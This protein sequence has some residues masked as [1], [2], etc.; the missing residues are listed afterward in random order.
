MKTLITF[1]FIVLLGI[2]SNAHNHKKSNLVINSADNTFIS[3]AINNSA[4]VAPSGQINFANMK[5]GKH[6]VKIFKNYMNP[7]G[8]WKSQLVYNGLISVPPASE[9]I[10]SLNFYNQLILVA[11]NPLWGYGHNFNPPPP[12]PPPVFGMAP[13]AFQQLVMT[14]GNTPF[15]NTRLTIA[16]QAIAANGITSEQV[17]GLMNM[18]TFESHKLDLA[19]YAYAFTADPNNYYI[20]NNGFTFTSSIHELNRFIGI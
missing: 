12:P 4:P 7:G 18:L 8:H 15:D 9:V 19:K 16:K 2:N 3:V 5:P 1:A 10:Y 17:L 11:S 13:H 20:V 14:I 6:R